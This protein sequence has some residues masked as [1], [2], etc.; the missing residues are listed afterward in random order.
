MPI[1][2]PSSTGT[3]PIELFLDFGTDP[4]TVTG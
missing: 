4:V 2:N 1:Y 3:T